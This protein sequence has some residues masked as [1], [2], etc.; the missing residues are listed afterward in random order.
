[1]AAPAKHQLWPDPGALC[2]CI[3]LEGGQKGKEEEKLSSWEKSPNCSLWLPQEAELSLAAVPGAP[4]PLHSS[5]LTA[6]LVASLLGWIMQ[7]MLWSIRDAEGW[8]ESSRCM[9]SFVDK[10]W[11]SPGF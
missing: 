11:H 6:L 4:R 8:E 2:C 5:H 9:N 7:E 3:P 10:V 1:M